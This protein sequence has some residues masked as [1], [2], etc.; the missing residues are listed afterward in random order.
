MQNLYISHERRLLRNV[1]MLVM[2]KCSQIANI[3]LT[4]NTSE[5]GNRMRHKIW[6]VLLLS[7]VLGCGN[8]QNG[9]GE[10]QIENVTKTEV[11][12][13]ED[14]TKTEIQEQ[15]EILKKQENATQ[16]EIQKQEEN[17]TK[18][19][20]DELVYTSDY[21]GNI[22]DIA[23][24]ED[25]RLYAICF[26]ALH[27]G[28]R[29]SNGKER[30]VITQPTQWLYEFDTN[31]ACV[32]LG[33]MIYSPKEAMTLEWAEDSLY[34][35]VL[36]INNIPVLYEVGH[37]SEV[38]SEVVETYKESRKAGEHDMQKFSDVNNLDIWTLQE[39]YRFDTFSAIKRLVFMEDRLYVYGVLTNPE[40]NAFVQNLE[41]LEMYVDTYTGQAIG[42]LDMKNLDAGV[43]LLPMDG[44]PQD[45]IK[46]T[47]DTLG[48]YLVGEDATSFWKY[49]PSKET[50]EQT[51]MAEV[52]FGG[53]A[54]DSVV[55]SEFAAYEDGC[56]YVKND[57]IV[58]YKQANGTEVEL[59]ESD[60]SV[61][62]LKTDGTFLYYY[63]NEWSEKEVRRVEISELL[64]SKT[65]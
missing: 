10:K 22:D 2:R 18:N 37:L 39:R 1:F 24:T 21:L 12:E 60:G 59:F 57:N 34:M 44:I 53:T 31:G 55:Y 5:W 63:S 9:D 36:G 58:C 19:E 46:L 35:V 56:F 30:L 64:G 52:K 47:E 20:T 49:T 45:M 14:E 43:T 23:V 4:R 11:L 54:E 38:Y 42:Y 33:E 27:E 51:D 65:E 48:V 61:Q 16:T 41:S 8:G 15:T 29:E 6:L 28:Y 26:Q 3:C 25:G 62:G 17:I 40:E 32:C 50:W 13:Q 7:F